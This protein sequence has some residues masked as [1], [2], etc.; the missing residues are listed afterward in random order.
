MQWKIPNF[1]YEVETGASPRVRRDSGH[2]TDLEVSGKDSDTPTHPLRCG[3]PEPWGPQ[4]IPNAVHSATILSRSWNAQSRRHLA[5]SASWRAS[6]S[7]WHRALH[8]FRRISASLLSSPSVHRHCV[9]DLQGDNERA[10][11]V[12]GP[13]GPQ[14]PSDWCR[15]WGCTLRKPDGGSAGIPARGPFRHTP[16]RD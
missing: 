4:P 9:F 5:T 14:V 10:E 6:F 2:S 1:H 7:S 16:N 11:E 8:C 15:S 13:S 12:A 3:R